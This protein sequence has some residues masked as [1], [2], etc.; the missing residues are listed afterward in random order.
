MSGIIGVVDGGAAVGAFGPGVSTAIPCDAG[1]ER[2]AAE[3]LKR[4]E[5]GLDPLVREHAL[6]IISAL[7]RGGSRSDDAQDRRMTLE[8][9]IDAEA[10]RVELGNGCLDLR[11]ATLARRSEGLPGPVVALV[12]RLADSWGISYDGQL[13]LWF[14]IAR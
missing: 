6:A 2:E 5:G 8:A 13:R 11:P 3:A 7:L 1:G 10:L 12:E 9:S 4:L 14:A